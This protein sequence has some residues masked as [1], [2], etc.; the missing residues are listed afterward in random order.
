MMAMTRILETALD[1][2]T[3]TLRKRVAPGD[4]LTDVMMLC[5][6]PEIASAHDPSID[7]AIMAFDWSGA[8]G[9]YVLNLTTQTIAPQGMPPSQWHQWDWD[10]LAWLD[11]RTIEVFRSEKSTALNIA[12]RDQIYAGYDSAALG[13]VHRYP[14]N[15]KDQVNMIAS[16]A[17]SMYPNLPVDWWTPFWCADTTGAWDYRPH[18]AAQIQQAGTDGKTA[19][20]VALSKNAALQQQLAAA[21]TIADIEAIAW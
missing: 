1:V 18:T 21:A 8:R 7:A 13:A 2:A 16:V 12:C 17:S 11:A 10:A 9:V 15:D 19:I 6:V 3:M 20:L 4:A 5:R 14:A